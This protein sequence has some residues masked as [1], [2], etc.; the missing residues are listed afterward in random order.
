[1]LTGAPTCPGAVEIVHRNGIGVGEPQ[2]A[3]VS[4]VTPV[5]RVEVTPE[6]L[7]VP[8]RVHDAT[9]VDALCLSD[10]WGFLWLEA[11]SSPTA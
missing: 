1:M 7:P 10:P 3:N 4:E 2:W 8:V 6:D 9:W 5:L 11:P